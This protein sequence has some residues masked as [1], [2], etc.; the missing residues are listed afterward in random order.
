MNHPSI[1]YRIR[2]ISPKAHL[3]AV[4]CVITSPEPQGQKISM[5]CWIPGSYMIRDFAK[6][7]IELTASCNNKPLFVQKL[8]KSSWQIAPCDGPVKLE[9]QVYAWDLSVRTAH[10]DQT[11]GYFNGTSVF[12]KVEGQETLPCQVDIQPPNGEVDGSWRVATG[13]PRLEAE[14]YGFGSYQAENYEALIDYPVEMSDF[15]LASFEVAGIPHDIVITGRHQADMTRLC[16]DL[17]PICES[18][19]ELFGELP[20]MERYLFMLMVVGGGYGGLEHRNSTSLLCSRADLPVVGK[21]EIGE[22]YRSLLG[23][24]SHEYFHTWNVKRIK[25]ELFLPYDLTQETHTQQLW[26]FEG[27]TAYYDD[28]S[29]VRSG[30][31]TPADYLL[32]LGQTITR[33]YRGAGRHIQT[34]AE[35]SFD[36]WTKFYKQDENAPNAIVS[37]YTQGS[38]IALGLDARIRTQTAG[39]LCLDDVMRKLWQDYGKAAVG[40]PEGYIESLASELCGEDLK[41]FF[42]AYLYGREEYPLAEWLYQLGIKLSWR[43]A[44]GQSDKGGTAPSHN[45]EFVNLGARYKPASLGVE[46]ITVFIDEPA[47]VAGLSAGDNVIAINGIQAS[48]GNLDNMLENA[49]AG[50]VW[51]VDA[52]RR[53]ELMHF[54]LTLEAAAANIAYLQLDQEEGAD[55][56]W[57]PWLKSGYNVAIK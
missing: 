42:D 44:E 56:R 33:V 15:T 39:K 17:R 55:K 34:V 26:A 8:D 41:P 6:N 9:Y 22:K 35:S 36:T 23:L 5:A 46:L 52:F 40:V 2:A 4:E 27:F 24:C 50:D 31:I 28:L 51:E 10:L 18:Q 45:T 57:H 43:S 14:L 54:S 16:E 25:P 3:F 1:F 30:R 21:Q 49:R 29:L 47:Q 20:E 13:M 12:I 32:L 53:D 38:L 11:H 48:N 19:I 37:Y 7:V